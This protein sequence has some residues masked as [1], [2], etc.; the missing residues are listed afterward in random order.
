MA[1]SSSDAAVARLGRPR[2]RRLHLVGSWY[3]WLIFLQSYT[4]LAVEDPAYIP[5][6]VLPVAVLVLR[7]A[8][9]RKL[10]ARKAH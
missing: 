6:A 3:V 4:P 7:V 5:L 10:R 9:W 1:I 2:W 8:R